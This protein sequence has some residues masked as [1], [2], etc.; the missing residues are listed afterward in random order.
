M[1]KK[2]IS[3]IALT[4]LL[5]ISFIS[6]SQNDKAAYKERQDGY[7]QNTIQKEI[8]QFE[9]HQKKSKPSTYLSVDFEGRTFPVK[10][11]DYKQFWHQP[12]LSQGATGTCWCF[13][14]TSFFESEVYRTTGQKIKLSEM[15]F[16]YNEYIERAR[17]FVTNHGEMYFGEGSEANAVPK[18]M[19][20]YGA[21]PEEIYSGKLAGQ[22]FHN[23]E[24]MFAE[25][26]TY[27]DWVKKTNF[28]NEETVVATIKSILNQYML[29]PPDKFNFNGKEYTPNSFLKDVVQIKPDDYFS[30]MCTKS[31]T[32]GQKGELVEPDNWWH[33]D[34]YYNVALDEFLL[35]FKESLKSGYTVSF[36]GDVSE[37][38]Y[39]RYQEVGIIPSFDIPAEYINE[40]SR[41]F[42]I[43]NSTTTDDHCMHIIGSK[44]NED[45]WWFL[46]KDS[47]SSAFDGPNKGYR[48]IHEDYIR[49]KVLTILVYKYGARDVLD[50]IIK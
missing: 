36:C 10:I 46:L 17:Y 3:L 24:Q 50:K 22:T 26:K 2:K 40:D 38:G 44:E 43:Y 1:K 33:N 41:E 45:G 6:K 31:A 13:A 32:Y 49:L 7:Y 11:E 35:I 14:S 21:I 48:F 28:W 25:M 34:D 47:S 42:R 16:V 37:P 9:K 15:Y 29:E 27:L 39:D 23:H 18:L 20:K 30:F 19:T 5:S 12:P 4:L 8:T